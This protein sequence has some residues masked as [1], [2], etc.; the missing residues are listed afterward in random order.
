M[1]KKLTDLN[2]VSR[3][4]IGAVGEPGQRVF[5]LQAS[6]S[7]ENVTLKIEKE[8]ARVL[9]VSASELLEELDEKYPRSYSKFDRPLTADLMLKEPI[10]PDFVVGQ[11]GLGYDQDQDMIV[12]VMQEI[13]IENEQDVAT[14]RFWATRAQVKALSEHALEVVDQGRPVCPLCDSP[15]GPDGHF[16]PKSNGYE[17]VQWN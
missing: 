13:Q 4:T 10:E 14:A 11:I 16:C 5:L 2:P 1:A 8:Q 3:I 15:I 17:R 12:L 9:A 7:S 6:Q